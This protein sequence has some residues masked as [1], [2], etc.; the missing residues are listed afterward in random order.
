MVDIVDDVSFVIEDEEA[1]ENADQVQEV[2]IG[3]GMAEATEIKAG[4]VFIHE[5][6]EEAQ[7]SPAIV[8]QSVASVSVASVTASPAEPLIPTV[9]DV[10]VIDELSK[11]KVAP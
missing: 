11:T 2:V 8:Q 1:R 10:Q 9:T 5:D 3:D 7:D 4:M 6:G